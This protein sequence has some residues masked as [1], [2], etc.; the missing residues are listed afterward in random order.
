MKIKD[1]LLPKKAN[2]QEALKKA[3]SNTE[4]S[5]PFLSAK[6]SASEKLGETV[7]KIKT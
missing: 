4:T 5:N 6:R 3:S 7:T 1:L 2:D